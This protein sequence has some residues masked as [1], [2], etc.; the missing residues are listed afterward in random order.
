MKRDVYDEYLR[1]F[2]KRDYESLLEYFSEDLR[3]ALLA[4]S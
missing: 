4:I 2:D 1:R 3:S